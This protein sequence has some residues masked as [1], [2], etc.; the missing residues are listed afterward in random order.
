[1]ISLQES[2]QNIICKENIRQFLRIGL[3]YFDQNLYSDNT[4]TE[5]TPIPNTIEQSL[6][7]DISLDIIDIWD[8][9]NNELGTLQFPDSR[10]TDLITLYVIIDRF[11]IAN[12][13][14]L[15]I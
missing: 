1:M 14:Y 5:G 2:L 9:F 8:Y 11:F 4:P 7:T 12:F 6:V 15:F 10:R 13:Q 3:F